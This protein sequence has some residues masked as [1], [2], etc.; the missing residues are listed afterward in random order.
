M[1]DVHD[2]TQIYEIG[3]LERYAPSNNETMI[4]VPGGW[5]YSDMSGCCFVPWD[6]EFQPQRSAKEASDEIG[7]LM[8]GHND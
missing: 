8:D 5:I 4:R 1:R 2:E 6:N 3:L 7:R